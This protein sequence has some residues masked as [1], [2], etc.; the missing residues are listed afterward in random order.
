ML[1]SSVHH[2]VLAEDNPRPQL[3]SL[4]THSLREISTKIPSR[5]GTQSE[6][7]IR[8]S[9]HSGHSRHSKDQVA[10]DRDPQTIHHMINPDKQSTLRQY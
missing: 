5:S 1:L 9:K 6:F 8:F 2:E 3:I 10:Y 4:P 7:V